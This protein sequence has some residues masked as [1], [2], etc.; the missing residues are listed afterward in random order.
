MTIKQKL[1][2]VL[3][4]LII[5]S[6][7]FIMMRSYVL[8]SVRTTLQEKFQALN[9]SGFKV[10]YDSI[11]IDWQ[12]NNIRVE[13]LVILKNP[14]DTSCVY[15]EFISV[16]LMNIHGL[17]VFPLML[18]REL[19]LKRISLDSMHAVMRM[20]SDFFGD[21]TV[22]AEKKNKF[23]FFVGTV[24]FN[25]AHV[26]Y[27]DSATCDHIANFNSSFGLTEI[28]LGFF[29]D[30]PLEISLSTIRFDSS[31]LELPKAFYTLRM[32]GT[33]I[34]LKKGLAHLD[35]IRISPH[36][37][38]IMFGRKKGFQV[39]RAEGVIPFINLRGLTYHYHDSLSVHVEKSDMQMF[40]KLF[41][42]KRL[43]FVKKLKVLPV[44]QLRKL[45]WGLKIDTF[46]I[47]K[48]YVEYE[49]FPINGEEAGKVFF[50]DLFA[51]VYKID[52]DRNRTEGQMELYAKSSFMGDGELKMN[53]TFPYDVSKPC[54]LGGSL[55][56]FSMT[57]LNPMLEP[58]A[59]A[60]VETGDLK[61]LAFK[62]N[63]NKVKSDG[64]V[65]LNYKNLRLVTYK[66]EEKQKAR[67]K[68]VKKIAAEAEEQ[69]DKLKTFVLNAFVI[70]KNMDERVSAEQR[71][72]TIDF[73][74]DTSKSVFNYWWKS[75]LSGIKSAYNLDKILL[76]KEKKEKKKEKKH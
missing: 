3:I 20:G 45:S 68:G 28:K 23:S 33:N 19:N 46:K 66:D 4:F 5:C 72:G 60:I 59:N 34:D 67:S 75:L 41:R 57:K 10:T 2:L 6:G 40:I 43:P 58:A 26:E 27:L 11:F 22:N 47:Y 37:N 56:D 9:E 30:K 7:A 63:Y 44:Q 65:E 32:R 70:R 36:Y 48:S 62:F 17:S 24:N 35:T 49:E 53:S 31:R 21:S 54:A 61:K 42:D 64:E 18:K 50:D 25:S 8:K 76:R 13:N 12:R 69:V 55:N 14:Y 51:Q 15:P 71:T 38:K 73:H 1:A 39:D 52:N 16:H 74:R 29:P